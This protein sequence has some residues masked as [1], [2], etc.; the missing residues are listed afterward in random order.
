LQITTGVYTDS[1]LFIFVH[2]Y[3]NITD[4]TISRYLHF[5]RLLECPSI[6][7]FLGITEEKS[8][9]FMILILKIFS[10]KRNVL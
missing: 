6:L 4:S 7:A 8:H 2:N 5:L 10:D 1:S 9:S 3:D